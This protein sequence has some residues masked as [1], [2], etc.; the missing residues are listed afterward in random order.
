MGCPIV[1][2]GTASSSRVAAMGRTILAMNLEQIFKAYD[3]RGTVPD[4]LDEEAAR[5]IGAAFARFAESPRIAVGRDCRDSSPGLAHAQAGVIGD[6]KRCR[7]DWC[8]VD[9][10]GYSGWLRTDEF[11]G[12]YPQ[13]VPPHEGG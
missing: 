12:I 3:V 13:E 4:Q 10:E 1:D 7:S 2:S 8:E 9:L 6:L 11:Y 5:R